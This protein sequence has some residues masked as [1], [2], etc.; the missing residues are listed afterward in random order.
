MDGGFVV[1]QLELTQASLLAFLYASMDQELIVVPRSLVR[2]L[3]TLRL[4]L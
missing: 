4:Y 1:F 2:R 3:L